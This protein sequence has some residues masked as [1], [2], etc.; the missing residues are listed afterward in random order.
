MYY[1]EVWH[2][3][4][5]LKWNNQQTCQSKRNAHL[6]S[7]H[8]CN[9][10]ISTL[11]KSDTLEIWIFRSVVHKGSSWQPLC[12][13]CILQGLAGGAK[14]HDGNSNLTC[15]EVQKRFWKVFKVLFTSNVL[16]ILYSSLITQIPLDW[17]T[18]MSA[19]VTGILWT[20]CLGNPWRAKATSPFTWSKDSV[21]WTPP[22]TH[23]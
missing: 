13:H 16:T 7:K 12:L 6:S 17:L 19:H 8:I 3:K 4:T 23:T 14:K 10:Q 2:L 20:A 9:V 15:Q 21:W 5:F 18:T 22:H 1:L 11:G